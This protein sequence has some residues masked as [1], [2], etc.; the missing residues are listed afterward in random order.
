MLRLSG[1]EL[2]SRWVPLIIVVYLDELCTFVPDITLW[3]E[4]TIDRSQWKSYR[5]LRSRWDF[6]QRKANKPKSL[7]SRKK[8]KKKKKTVLELLKRHWRVSIVVHSINW[9]NPFDDLSSR[10]N[11]EWT[12]V[13]STRSTGF[14]TNKRYAILLEF[15]GDLCPAG[16]CLSI[17]RF[18]SAI[19]LI[20]TENA[21]LV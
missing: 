19:N 14:R 1:F 8:K 18:I 2:Y 16:F 11:R 13:V 5:S 12:N 21:A 17:I 9:T 15:L 4:D 10:A 6:V 3:G 7:Y 20:C